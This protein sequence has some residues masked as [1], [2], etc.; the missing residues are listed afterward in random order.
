MYN[1]IWELAGLLSILFNTNFL[2]SM[3]GELKQKWDGEKARKSQF[4]DVAKTSDFPSGKTNLMHLLAELI[5]MLVTFPYRDTDIYT[6]GI[7][8]GICPSLPAFA[9]SKRSDLSSMGF[10]P[11]LSSTNQPTKTNPILS[12]IHLFGKLIDLV[13]MFVLTCHRL[14]WVFTFGDEEKKNTLQC[15][16]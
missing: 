16:L 11:L 13:F 15:S 10:S 7:P 5:H 6:I 1:R 4:E 3:F 2:Q 9:T 14:S 12:C 8:L